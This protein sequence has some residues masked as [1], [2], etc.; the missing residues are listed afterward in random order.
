M[1]PLVRMETSAFV[2]LLLHSLYLGVLNT[3]A[4]ERMQ[5]LCI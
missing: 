1:T 2:V 4:I 3:F 5:H